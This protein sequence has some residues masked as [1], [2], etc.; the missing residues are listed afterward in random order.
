MPGR[1]LA[2]DPGEK[3][4]GIALS[5][6]T[7][8]LATPLKVI[9]HVQLN[10]DCKQIVQLAEEHG[11]ELIIIGTVQGS[12]GEEIR[13]TRHAQKMADQIRKT[14]QITVIL[15]DESNSTKIARQLRMDMG[16]KRKDRSGHMDDQA[17]AVF[18]QN[19]L[20]VQMD[21]SVNESEKE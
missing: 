8:T 5:D 14:T 2:V 21:R 16:A 19:Y 6:P 17:A 12:E 11:V 1:V 7:G 15:W 13:Q 10:E 4:L 9:R 3:N 18:L 20:N